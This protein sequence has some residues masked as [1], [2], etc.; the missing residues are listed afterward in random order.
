[1]V[2]GRSPYR[3]KSCLKRQ[4]HHD[5]EPTVSKTNYYSFKKVIFDEIMIKEYPPVIGDNPAVSEGK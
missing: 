4:H 5:D 3:L 1:M 2:R